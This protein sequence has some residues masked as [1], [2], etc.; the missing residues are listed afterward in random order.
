MVANTKNTNPDQPLLSPIL[1]K[2]WKKKKF[3]RERDWII[4][5]DNWI[6]VPIKDCT[7]ETIEGV[8]R[9]NKNNY[10]DCE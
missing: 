8:V 9:D 10:I 1:P 7:P 6:I 5:L 4:E 2:R 3:Q